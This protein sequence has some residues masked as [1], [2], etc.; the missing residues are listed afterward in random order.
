M[1]RRLGS[2]DR[3]DATRIKLPTS[4]NGIFPYIMRG[5]NESVAYF[6]IKLEVDRLMDYIQA[7]KGTDHE[8]SFFEAV[9]IAMVKILRLRPTLNRYIVGRRLYQ[10]RDVV[11]SFIAKRQFSDNGEEYNALLRVKPEDDIATLLGKLRGEIRAAKTGSEAHGDKI[12]DF[13]FSLPRSV[14]RLAVRLLESWDF[15]V[16]TPGFL[17][18]MDP[19]RASVY[20]SNLG[21]IGLGAPYHHLFEWGTCSLFVSIGQIH[22]AIV[23]GDDDQPAVRRVVDLKASLDERI[24]DGYYDA[25]SLD[26][27]REYFADPEQLQSI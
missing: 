24:A 4:F 13:F 10:R 20:L 21:S 8:I 26:L 12:F 23:V 5:R 3:Y 15:Y 27:F 22:K 7:S 2:Q 25:R 17:R 9:I 6:P 18:A 14:L 11:I 1:A 19:L 16:D